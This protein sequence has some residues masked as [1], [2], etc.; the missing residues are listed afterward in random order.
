MARA[1][2]CSRFELAMTWGCLRDLMMEAVEA[3]DDTECFL[4]VTALRQCDMADDKGGLGFL[5]GEGGC[6]HFELAATWGLLAR[7]NDEAVEACDGSEW[8]LMVVVL[9][10]LEGFVVLMA[11]FR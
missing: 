1:G 5:F 4:T 10:E 8:L 9:C 7:S 3:C 6:S 2:G 11:A